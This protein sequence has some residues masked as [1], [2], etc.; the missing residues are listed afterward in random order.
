M[1]SG[2][3]ELPTFTPQGT[4]YINDLLSQISGFL[5]QAAQGFQQFLPGGGGGQPIID[6]AMRQY[7]QQTIPSIMN[8][9][10][11]NSGRG[12]S[13]LNQALAAS[14]ANLNTDL[15]S[16]LAQ[17]QLTA[18]QGLGGLGLGGGQLGLEGSKRSFMQKSP[19]FLQSLLLGFLPG[20][21]RSAGSFLGGLF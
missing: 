21:S 20:A 19:N 3:K 15:A 14:A 10:G 11:S 18:A 8:A 16:Q 9:F 7:Q 5:P 4:S 17:L 13:A 6:Q 2:Y 12:S 1:P